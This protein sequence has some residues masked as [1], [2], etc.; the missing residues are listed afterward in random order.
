MKQETKRNG[1]QPIGN[2]I[3]KSNIVSQIILADLIKQEH[4]VFPYLFRL[5][6]AKL[7]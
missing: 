7:E 5:L 1:P 2:Q 3:P 4:Q 6:L